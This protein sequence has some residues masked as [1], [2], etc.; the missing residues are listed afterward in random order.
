M[1]KNK[2]NERASG[3][4]RWFTSIR[5]AKSKGSLV[6][7]RARFSSDYIRA[8]IGT[9]RMLGPLLCFKP[10][11][12]EHAGFALRSV[13]FAPE[14]PRMKGASSRLADELHHQ[15]SCRSCQVFPCSL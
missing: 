3:S 13:D 10:T 12:M 8:P 6:G 5:V 1:E 15:G 11:K 4:I 2:A 14:S 7:S 9:T